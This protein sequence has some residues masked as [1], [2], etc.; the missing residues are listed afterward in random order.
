MNK[1]GSVSQWL[2]PL[3]WE[4]GCQLCFHS[5]M[6]DPRLVIASLQT[7]PEKWEWLCG[8]LL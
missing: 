2:G 7:S 8:E 5:L 3:S 4:A 6:C 1:A